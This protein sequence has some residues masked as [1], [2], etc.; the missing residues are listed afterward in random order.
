[1]EWIHLAHDGIKHEAVLN[2]VIYLRVPK[3][4]GDGEFIM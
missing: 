2:A 4:A 1:M 3:E